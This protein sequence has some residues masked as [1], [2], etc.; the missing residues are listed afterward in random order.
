MS[1]AGSY[2]YSQMS[3]AASCSK[4]EPILLLAVTVLPFPAPVWPCVGLFPC[5]KLL[6]SHLAIGKKGKKIPKQTSGLAWR[7]SSLHQRNV[8]D[9]A[10]KDEH[11]WKA[12]LPIN[13]KQTKKFWLNVKKWFNVVRDK[14]KC[15]GEERPYSQ[16]LGWLGVAVYLQPKPKEKYEKY[17]FSLDFFHLVF[18]FFE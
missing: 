4:S 11:S 13:T 7:N 17:S 2:S 5:T 10:R 15:R 14:C 1:E 12:R 9:S 6:K 8:R 18:W 3:Q 16:P